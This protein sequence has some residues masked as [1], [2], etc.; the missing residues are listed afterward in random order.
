VLHSDG[1]VVI[2]NSETVNA[3]PPAAFSRDGAKVLALVDPGVGSIWLTEFAVATGKQRRVFE[4][5]V[6]DRDPTYLPDGRIGLILNE[7]AKPTPRRCSPRASSSRA[8][9]TTSPP[10]SPGASA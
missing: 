4:L 1:T 3:Y 6:S 9:A 8:T 2:L 7:G 10:R 5:G